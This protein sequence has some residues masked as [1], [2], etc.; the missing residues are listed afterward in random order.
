M[1]GFK[2]Q[3]TRS[4]LLGLS[5][6]TTPEQPSLCSTTSKQEP[7]V[8]AWLPD[9]KS[10]LET[11]SLLATHLAPQITSAQQA[12]HSR[13]A[14]TTPRECRGLPQLAPPAQLTCP[15]SRRPQALCC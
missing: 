10:R 6:S 9:A 1:S 7:Q 11:P 5:N 4:M 12:A 15:E 2:H 13:G 3:V 14:L 8:S